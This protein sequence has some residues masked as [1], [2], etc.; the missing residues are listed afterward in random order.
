MPTAWKGADHDV[1]GGIKFVDEGEGD[2]PEPASHPVPLHG[3]TD[4]LADDESDTGTGVVD[5]VTK[6]VH[7]NIR[8]RGSNPSLHGGSEIARPGHPILRWEQGPTNPDGSGRQCATA[9][10]APT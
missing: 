10:G 8:L 5:V 2:M 4:C 3:I 7:D 6:N 9:L 1:L